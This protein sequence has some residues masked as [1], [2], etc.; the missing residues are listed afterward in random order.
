MAEFLYCE[1]QVRQTVSKN[2]VVKKNVKFN[3]DYIFDIRER[4]EIPPKQARMTC[5][6]AE[7]LNEQHKLIMYKKKCFEPAITSYLHK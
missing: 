4:F 1:R 6:N 5:N 7:L 2:G 3:V